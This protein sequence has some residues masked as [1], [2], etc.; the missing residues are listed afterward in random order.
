MAVQLTALAKEKEAL[1][2]TA[3][4][5]AEGRVVVRRSKEQ[6][7]EVQSPFWAEILGICR[8]GWGLSFA[9]LRRDCWSESWAGN[10]PLAPGR[11]GRPAS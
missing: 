6:D 3:L 4:G 7:G 8:G 11:A 10:E 1:A 9:C 2:A 5:R